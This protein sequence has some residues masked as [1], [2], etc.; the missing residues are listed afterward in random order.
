MSTD[1]LDRDVR[2]HVFQHFL[3]AALPPTANQTAAALGIS[4]AEARA[5]YEHL[6]ADHVF[7]L[8][9]GTL[10]I[11]MANPLSAIPT[12]FPVT[13]EG[14]RF[15]G[16]CAWD[17]LGVVAMLGGTGIIRTNCG[18]CGEPMTLKLVDSKLRSPVGVVHF[19]VPVAHW[20]DDIVYT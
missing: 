15:Y 17:A 1:T 14:K 10:D 19:A 4:L 18:C 9:P 2:R 5:A 6:A 11:R 8:E 16:A 3:E 20:W 12:D 13:V 7:V